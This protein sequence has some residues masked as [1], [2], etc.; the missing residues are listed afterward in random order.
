[1]RIEEQAVCAQSSFTLVKKISEAQILSS[2]VPQMDPDTQGEPY[3]ARLTD[4][5]L[6]N[7]INLP[8]TV[9]AD[10]LSF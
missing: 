6:N 3:S 2:R 5:E 4:N 1:M 10:D 8:R 9:K 7:L